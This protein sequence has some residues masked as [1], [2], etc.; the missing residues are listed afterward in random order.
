M[1]SKKINT[2]LNIWETVGV[3]VFAH[4]PVLRSDGRKLNCNE[5]LVLSTI[6]QL[7]VIQTFVE[8]R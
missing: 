1:V 6:T 2:T 5:T 3:L 4:E 7:I 8:F